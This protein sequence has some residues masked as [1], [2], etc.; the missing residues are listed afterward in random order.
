[1]SE[2]GLLLNTLNIIFPSFHNVNSVENLREQD[3]EKVNEFEDHVF[4]LS[5]GTNVCNQFS[6]KIVKELELQL[7]P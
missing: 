1:M 4:S 5:K 6:P 3:D 7:E 2:I